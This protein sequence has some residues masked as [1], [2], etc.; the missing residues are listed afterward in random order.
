[1]APAHKRRNSV[2]RRLE[3]TVG[4]KNNKDRKHCASDPLRFLFVFV[5]VCRNQRGDIVH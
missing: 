2:Q 1:M 3:Q 5:E 4:I